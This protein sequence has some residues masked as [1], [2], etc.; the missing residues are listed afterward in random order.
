MRRNLLVVI[1]SLFAMVVM[2]Q[3]SANDRVEVVYFHW[4]QRCP[5]CM[6]IEKYAREVVE[7][8]FADA[9]QQGDVFFKVVDIS[10]EEG[11]RLAKE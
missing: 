4:K 6:A 7:K 10:T 5:T 9:K 1:M 8:E 2:A 3:T 11:K